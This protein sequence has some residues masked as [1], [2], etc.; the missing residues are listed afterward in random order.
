MGTFIGHILPGVF[1]S[2]IGLWHLLNII[3]K[4]VSNPGGFH[5]RAWFPT[6]LPGGW[7]YVELY[8]IILGSCISISSELIFWQPTHQPFGEHWEIPI[9][10]MAQF[11]HASM[12]LFF[13]IFGITALCS[14]LI[15]RLPFGLLHLV[16]SIAFTQEFLLFY[17][18][19]G[20]HMGIEGHYHWLLRLPIAAILFCGAAEI[21]FPKSFFLPFVRS[22]ALILQ[23]LW[24]TQTAFS[25]WVP[26]C[27]AMHC[28]MAGWTVECEDDSWTHRAK[29]LANLQFAW[30]LAATLVATLILFARI[31]R[32]HGGGKPF[33]GE[34]EGECDER[35]S[36]KAGYTVV[37]EESGEILSSKSGS[38]G[39]VTPPHKD[40]H[41][42]F[43]GSLWKSPSNLVDSFH[44]FNLGR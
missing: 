41:G 37:D 30:Y 42:T 27:V 38:P 31:K 8:L 33:V 40:A 16:A 14:E 6:K 22:I 7:K 3:R 26:S 35:T 28:K 12:S 4:F 20:D 21:G 24:F 11:E 36:L 19:S 18:H 34:D 25:I 9:Y 44:A 43:I 39:E 17:F 15:E 29:A 13:L 5:T 10:N 1:F 2:G 32:R 23:G